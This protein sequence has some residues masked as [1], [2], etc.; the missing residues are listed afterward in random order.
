MVLRVSCLT[1][2][3]RRRPLY[4]SSQNLGN[5]VA[6]ERLMPI[7]ELR[8][9]AGGCVPNECNS[10]NVSGPVTSKTEWKVRR[11]ERDPVAAAAR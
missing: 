4:Y 3:L 1:S 2:Q 9:L 6:E 8:V 7:G 11:N 10:E 5:G